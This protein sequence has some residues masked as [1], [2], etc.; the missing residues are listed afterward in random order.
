MFT[1]LNKDLIS[2]H[3]NILAFINYYVIQ[4]LLLLQLNLTI[5]FIKFIVIKQGESYIK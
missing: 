3:I 4:I 2:K 1:L 5:N